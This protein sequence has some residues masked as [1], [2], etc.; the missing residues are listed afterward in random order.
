MSRRYRLNRSSNCHRCGIG[1]ASLASISRPQQR[2]SCSQVEFNRCYMNMRSFFAEIKAAFARTRL[3]DEYEH[4]A[5]ALKDGNLT[6][7]HKVTEGWS[8]GNAWH[9]LAIHY[10]SFPHPSK[11]AELATHAFGKAADSTHWIDFVERSRLAE[12]CR[13][14]FNRRRFLGIGITPDYVELSKVLAARDFRYREGAGYELELAWIHALGPDEL[15]DYK[16]S[17]R[18]LC[19]ARLRWGAFQ[20]VS[21]PSGSEDS[22]A[23]VLTQSLPISSRDEIEIEARRDEIAAEKR[24]QDEWDFY[25]R[26]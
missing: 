16:K 13:R 19:F 11:Y 14:E 4:A 22:I 25:A 5:Q 10:S 18:Y 12:V 20:K 24:Y 26:I 17:W 1:I 21:L 8:L 7:M 15:R 6:P 3:I 23:A 2:A 9:D